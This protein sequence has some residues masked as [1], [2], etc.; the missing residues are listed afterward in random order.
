MSTSDVLHQ[1]LTGLQ[2]VEGE[3]LLFAAFWFIISAMDEI[4]ID[5]SWIWLRL[6]GRVDE[7]RL[8]KDEET[9]PLRGRTAVFIPTWHE[10]KVI[11]YTIGHMLRA[12]PQ[13][14][15]TLYVG[16]YRRA[17]QR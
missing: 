8:E 16:C 2:V 7:R 15:L 4:T 6:S 17:V 3:L 1:V 10:A 14:Q 11:G 9:R 13:Q 12:W 5:L